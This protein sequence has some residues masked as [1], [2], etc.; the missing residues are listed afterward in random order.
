[1]HVYLKAE[2]AGLPSQ[3]PQIEEMQAPTVPPHELHG[4]VHAENPRKPGHSAPGHTPV[5]IFITQCSI[6]LCRAPSLGGKEAGEVVRTLV[7]D[8]SLTVRSGELFAIMGGSG[9]G[10]TTLLNVIAGRYKASQLR[11]SEGKGF[12]ANLSE[13]KKAFDWSSFHV[14]V[15]FCP[16]KPRW[17]GVSSSVPVRVP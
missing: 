17:M 2:G 8:V 4:G 15:K 11:V 9:S 13:K 7:K 3:Q 5:N 10:K 16:D 1:M 12:N 14:S 6:H